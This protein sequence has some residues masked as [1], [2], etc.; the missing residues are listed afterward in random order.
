MKRTDGFVLKQINQIPYLL[1][2][3]QRIAE[4][5]R[6]MRLNEAGVFL[7]N[8]LSQAG[9]RD[10]L[11]TLFALHYEALPSEIPILARDMNA[12]LDEL[13]TWGMLEDEKEPPC[14]RHKLYLGG[15]SV[16]LN[17]PPELSIPQFDAFC[18]KK[19]NAPDFTIHIKS[20]SGLSCSPSGGQLLV[21]TEELFVIEQET[22]YH[23]RFPLAPQITECR[24][25]K[26][27]TR[28]NLYVVPPFREPLLSD[29]FHAIR[30][31]FL[32]RAQQSGRIA[33]HSASL[34]YREKTWL[35]AGSSGT[36]KSTHTN[37]WNAWFH[38][39]VINGDLNLIGLLDGQPMVF[40]T[41]WCGTSG[42]FHTGKLPLGGIIHL[43]QNGTNECQPL[44]KDAQ[45]L[46][47]L[48]RTISPSWTGE[49]MDRNLQL[50]ASISEKIY[51][52]RLLCTKTPEAAFFMRQQ[53]DAFFSLKADDKKI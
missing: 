29:L 5:R 28:A 24:L 30:L 9:T 38:T 36:G 44:T 26:D 27:G 48:Y 12:F 32:Y 35:F 34:Y 40:G 6:G 15:L 51:N 45:T 53:I 22:E 20:G 39:P 49:L 19:D 17:T 25:K 1:P 31:L 14:A 23:I 37:L 33:I 4:H 10:E 46:S 43:K 3:G 8:H 42:V 47:L 52:T 16:D 41:P 21:C 7:W 11:L 50:A 13:C 18:A 2:Y